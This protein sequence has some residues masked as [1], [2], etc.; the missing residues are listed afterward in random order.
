MWLRESPC[1]L[2]HL[3]FSASFSCFQSVIHS[4]CH[5]RDLAGL[6]TALGQQGRNIQLTGTSRSLLGT[7]QVATRRPGQGMVLPGCLFGFYVLWGFSALIL[8][9]ERLF[10]SQYFSDLVARSGAF[11]DKAFSFLK[12]NRRIF[13]HISFFSHDAAEILR[14]GADSIN[15]R[16]ACG[17]ISGKMRVSAQKLEAVRFSIKAP[18]KRFSSEARATAISLRWCAFRGL[19]KCKFHSA[20][21]FS[22]RP[23]LRRLHVSKCPWI[24]SSCPEITREKAVLSMKLCTLLGPEFSKIECPENWLKALQVSFIEGVLALALALARSLSFCLVSTFIKA[25][26]Q[27]RTHV[28]PPTEI[29][30]SPSATPTAGCSPGVDKVKTTLRALLFCISERIHLAADV[31]C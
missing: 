8:R 22:E 31:S 30:S 27:C 20:R 13:I 1:K 5:Q 26:L 14:F 7:G 29:H 12:G 16:A 6:V 18:P 21:R 25:D 23:A 4:V 19:Y 10:P 17:C 28:D 11:E 15:R 2:E 3:R 24:L 9:E